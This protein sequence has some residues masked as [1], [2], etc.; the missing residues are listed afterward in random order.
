[1]LRAMSLQ[2]EGVPPVLTHVNNLLAA[3]L[4]DSRFVTCFFGLMDPLEPSLTYASAGHGPMLFYTRGTD[5]FQQ[6]AA[7]SLPLGIM[8]S[9]PY[10]EVLRFEFDS[11]DMAIITTDGFFEAANAAGEQF[12][13]DRMMDLLRRDRDL[14]AQQMIRNLAQ[15]V[16]AFVGAAPQADDLT[17]VVIRRR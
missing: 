3:D 14:P 11:G 4:G 13:M 9:A 12:G 1:M 8:E 7:T 15:A 16:T 6:V 2:A 17:A 5:T 10:D